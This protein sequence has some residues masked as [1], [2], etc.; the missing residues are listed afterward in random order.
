MVV[1]NG[2]PATQAKTLRSL[3]TCST[4]LRRMTGSVSAAIAVVRLLAPTVDLAEDLEREDLVL[5]TLSRSGQARKPDSRKR[6]YQG[7][8]LAGVSARGEQALRI[9]VP[10]VFMSSKSSHRR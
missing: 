4:C 5:V 3:R 2:W 7:T 9:P 8:G 1:M 6:P 10:R